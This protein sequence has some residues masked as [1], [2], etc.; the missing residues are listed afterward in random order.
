MQHVLHL[1]LR[2]RANQWL[3]PI[4]SLQR[5]SPRQD[6]SVIHT[7]REAQT[8]NLHFSASPV[9]RDLIAC[10]TTS[11]YHVYKQR[12]TSLGNETEEL[13]GRRRKGKG[14]PCPGSLPLAMGRSR[15]PHTEPRSLG[16]PSPSPPRATLGSWV[17]PRKYC[18]SVKLLFMHFQESKNIYICAP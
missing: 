16:W 9:I 18:L 11:V 17:F 2:T 3:T 13:M 5:E 10:L 14:R 8:L 7:Q 4:A 1:T 12:A 6:L 15:Q